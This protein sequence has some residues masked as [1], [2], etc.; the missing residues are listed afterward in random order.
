MYLQLL[1]VDNRSYSCLIRPDPS[2]PAAQSPV[3]PNKYTYIAFANGFS[4]IYILKKINYM[5][6]T[7]IEHGLITI[8]V[9]YIEK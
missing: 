7:Y 8:F 6:I 4:S 9:V 5:Q 3:V 2:V 1:P